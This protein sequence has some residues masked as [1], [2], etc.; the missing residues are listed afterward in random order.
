MSRYSLCRYYESLFPFLQ[1]RKGE[2][3]VR[4]QEPAEQ[5]KDSGSSEAASPN[6]SPH[7]SQTAARP[8]DLREPSSRQPGSNPDSNRVAVSGGKYK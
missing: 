5:G 8:D 4:R 6:C 3:E 1:E 7:G 2:E